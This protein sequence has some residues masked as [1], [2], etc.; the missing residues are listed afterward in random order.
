[1]A[2]KPSLRQHRTEAL[3]NE[4]N[5]I[6][7]MN[8]FVL[9]IPFL[10]VSAVFVQ[11]SIIDTSLPI[12][13]EG[14]ETALGPQKKGITLTVTINSQGYIIK[15][16]LKNEGAQQGEVLISSSIKNYISLKGELI[17]KTMSGRYDFNALRGAL[18]EI[19]NEFP[20]EETI[21]VIPDEYVLYDDIIKTMD[22]SRTTTSIRD[23]GMKKEIRLFENAVIATVTGY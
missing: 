1:M 22:A 15:G 7:V 14:G 19:K 21:F 23:D 6:P 20:D 8:L 11:V 12:I 9:L 4:L 5:I 3:E 18:L 17:P 10:L 16:K 2:L 13:R